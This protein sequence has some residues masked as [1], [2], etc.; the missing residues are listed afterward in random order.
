MAQKVA[1]VDVEEFSCGILHHVVARVTVSYPKHISSYGL[2]C[3][4]FQECP[5]IVLESVLDH[6][7]VASHCELWLYSNFSQEKVHDRSLLKWALPVS[8]VYMH[9]CNDGR[10]VNK[11]DV[12]SFKSAF[13]D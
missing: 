1:K 7:L 10:I 13:H 12:A 4:R 9:V 3:Q 2:A 6:F 11:F 5:V 8:L